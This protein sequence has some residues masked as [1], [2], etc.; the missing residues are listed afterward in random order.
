MTRRLV[1][2]TAMMGVLLVAF[3]ATAPS[4]T[5]QDDSSGT[6]KLEAPKALAQSSN[7]PVD[8]AGIALYLKYEPTDF[9]NIHAAATKLASD[10]RNTDGAS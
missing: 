10:V 2:A 6:I 4:E 5:S 9:S 8:Y 1:Y 3:W 7:F